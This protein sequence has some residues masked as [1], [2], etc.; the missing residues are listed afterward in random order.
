MDFEFCDSL[1]ARGFECDLEAGH[2][3]E[4]MNIDADLA[5]D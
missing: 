3:D 4:H 2:E 1:S 5:W